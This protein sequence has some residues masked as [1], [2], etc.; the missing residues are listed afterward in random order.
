MKKPTKSQR[1]LRA[2]A[3]TTLM[4]PLPNYGRSL[5]YTVVISFLAGFALDLLKTRV[6]SLSAIG[7][8]FLFGG[9][10]GFLIMCVPAILAAAF[11]ASI[12]RKERFRDRLRHFSF[13][14]LL[15]VVVSAILYILALL[16]SQNTNQLQTFVLLANSIIFAI[17]FVALFVTLNYGWKAIPISLIQPL[18]SIS[19]LSIYNSFLIANLQDPFTL[20]IKFVISSIVLLFALASIFYIINAP[21]R[22]NFGISTLQVM[23]LFFAQWTYGSK[24]LEGVLAEM[25]EKVETF[26]GTAL[27]RS[28]KTKKIKAA[29]LI[30]YVHF[31]PVGNLGGSEF[32]ALLSKP[33]SRRMNAPVSVFHATVNHDFNPVYSSVHTKLLGTYAKEISA[34]QKAPFSKTAVAQLMESSIGNARIFSITAGKDGFFAFSNAPQSTED[35][36]F[37]IGLI[38]M[39]KLLGRS[40][41]NAILTDMHNS[42]TNGDYMLTGTPQFYEL[43]DLADKYSMGRQLPFKFG[44]HADPLGDFGISQGIG[45][46]GMIV[47][48][49]EIGGRKSCIILIDANNVLPDFRRE[50]LLKVLANGKR[51]DFCD[52]FTTDT[53]AVNTISG[54]H[55]P[56]GRYCDRG[57]L[58]A[59]IEEAIAGAIL[60]LEPAEAAMSIKRIELDVLG[61]RRSPEVIS[62][63]NSIVSIAKIF[64]PSILIIS[65]LIAFLLS[66]AIK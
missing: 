57:K 32:P 29:W 13:I 31:G 62:T 16:V 15:S 55:N 28:A 21:A 19:F 33:I 46:M 49:F 18:L 22:R 64:A 58:A 2:V 23:A 54:I 3:I 6:L 27:F 39:N 60:D 4:G 17:W 24:R 66:L 47:S 40:L 41:Q 61:V 51:F 5:L 65:L 35:I 20:G 7:D 48:V 8:Y 36:E 53:H 34:M 14:S 10:E 42:K 25:G 12:T 26:Y 59:R 56:L 44:C 37:P 52:V 50:I 9:T 45:K 11:A 63:I 38:L 1:D 43:Y 30:P